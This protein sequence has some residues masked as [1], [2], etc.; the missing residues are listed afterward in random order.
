MSLTI[1]SWTLA[2]LN[3]FNQMDLHVRLSGGPEASAHHMSSKVLHMMRS[4]VISGVLVRITFAS[5]P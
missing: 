1:H 3:L 5:Q 2:L 4:K